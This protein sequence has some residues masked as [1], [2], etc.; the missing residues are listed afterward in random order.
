MDFQSANLESMRSA[1][2]VAG[3]VRNQKQS[4]KGSV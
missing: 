4:A 3:T 1:T 2:M